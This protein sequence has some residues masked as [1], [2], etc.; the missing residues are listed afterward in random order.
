MA[1]LNVSFGY[2][3]MV[4]AICE[5]VRRISRKLLPIHIYSNLVVE[6]VSCF[7]LAACW[8]EREMLVEIGSWGG[9][10]GTDVV[11][12]LLFVL[13]LIH[14][15]TFDGAEANPLVTM[16]ELL[17][18]N[19]SMKASIVKLFAQFGGTE[20]A[21]IVA[22]IY[23]SWELTDFHLIQ[24]LMAID[25]SSSIKTSIG[26][27]IFAEAICAFLFHLVL[28]KLERTIVGYRIIFK[29]LLITVV[30][31][32]VGPYTAALFNPALAFSF[33]FHCSGNTWS[34]YMAVYWLSPFVAMFLAVFL[35]NG[36]VPLLFSTNLMYSQKP[37]YKIPKGKS[38]PEAGENKSTKR[39]KG[40][41]RLENNRR[42]GNKR[43]KFTPFG[44]Q[45]FMWL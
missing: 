40:D 36:N 29:A 24:N 20:L 7:Q 1:G 30:S 44:L 16:Q 18:Y 31:C 43:V 5:F 14:E 42:G 38:T 22:K 11:T 4:I 8:F 12:T 27:G 28:M 19:S 35:F 37:K 26:Q 32:V 45:C 41:E 2:F 6:F 39:E 10:Y 25:C 34:E 23:W 15:A 33:T 13:F 21:R 9:G 3:C 17:R